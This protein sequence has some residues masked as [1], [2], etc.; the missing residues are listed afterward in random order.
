MLAQERRCLVLI[1][2]A[3]P[4]PLF[5]NNKRNIEGI[6]FCSSTWFKVEAGAVASRVAVC[7]RA[8]APDNTMSLL[9]SVRC[10]LSYHWNRTKYELSL[11]GAYDAVSRRSSGGQNNGVHPFQTIGNH[12]SHTVDDMARCRGLAN[13]TRPWPPRSRLF[14]PTRRPQTS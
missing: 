12:Q 1:K 2:S 10:V 7:R 8:A 4:Q 3:V 14:P 13:P 9:A 11:K 5:F 6:L